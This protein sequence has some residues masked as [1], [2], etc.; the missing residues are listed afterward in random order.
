MVFL[1]TLAFYEI[2]KSDKK[3]HAGKSNFLDYPMLLTNF[4]RM[5]WKE[6]T[7]GYLNNFLLYFF[8]LLSVSSFPKKTLNAH[9]YS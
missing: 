6:E 8:V 5:F 1:F 2:H 7:K 9:I 4:Q 3:Y